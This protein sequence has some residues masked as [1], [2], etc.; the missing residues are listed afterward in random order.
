MMETV[1]GNARAARVPLGIAS[2]A[3]S[4]LGAYSVG[5][6]AGL[7]EATGVDAWVQARLAFDLFVGLGWVVLKV[8]VLIVLVASAQDFFF[9]GVGKL[10]GSAGR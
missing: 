1:L 2:Y 9:W 7:S 10:I 8:W 4:V 3:A 5:W 6:G